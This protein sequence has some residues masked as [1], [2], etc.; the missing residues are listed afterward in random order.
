M[1]KKEKG[2]KPKKKKVIEPEVTTEDHRPKDPPGYP[3]TK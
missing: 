3:P 1:S 2:E